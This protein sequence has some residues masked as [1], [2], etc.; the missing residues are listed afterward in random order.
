MRLASLQLSLVS[1]D[2]SALADGKDK[3][4]G[5]DDDKDH[6]HGHG[7]GHGNGNGGNNGDHNPG[8]GGPR[9]NDPENCGRVSCLSRSALA[10]R[11]LT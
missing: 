6:G 3:G 5:K 8:H 7:P 2:P 1:A 11:S 10:L 9:P 4:K